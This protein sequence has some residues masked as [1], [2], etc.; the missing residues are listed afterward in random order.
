MTEV[1]LVQPPIQDFYLT[2]KRTI[3]YG[4]ACIAACLRESGI[5]VE[6]LDA[7]AVNKSRVLEVP[8]EMG[9]LKPYYGR[10]DVSAFSLFHQFRHYGYSHQHLGTLIRDK[11]PF[12]VGISSLFTAYSSQALTTAET[13]KRFYPDCWIVMGGHHPTQLPEQVMACK[14]VD[15]V[16]R[17]EGEV[18]ML[19][20]VKALLN[21]APLEHVPGIVFRKADNTLFMS[22][23]AWMDSKTIYPVPAMDLVNRKFYARKQ[24][25]STVVVAGRGCPM[26]CSYC[27]VGASSSW[28]RFRQRKVDEVIAEIESQIARQDIGFIDFEDENLTLNRSWFLDLL[29]QIIARFGHLDVELRAMNGLFPPSLDAGMVAAMKAAGFKTLNLA[30]GSTSAAQLARFHRPDVRALFEK[31]LDWAS[32][33]SMDTVSY[34][35]AAAPGQDPRDS[36]SDLLYLAEK[37]TLVGFSV[38]YPAP[39]SADYSLCAVKG[40]LPAHFSLMRSTALP[41][42]DTTTRVQAVTLLRLSRLLNFM[43]LLKDEG[44]EMPVPERCTQTQVDDFADRITTGKKLLQWFFHDGWIRGVEPDGTVYVH[45]TDEA[46]GSLFLKRI[47][48]IALAGSTAGRSPG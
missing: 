4:L 26:Q 30:L 47:R 44:I 13:I 48:K 35:I 17:G 10:P 22:E 40:L 11:K 5:H 15:F 25:G 33:N 2:A 28:A 37:Q 16:L 24:R 46:L 41:V 43:K 23:P 21:S 39:G 45:S 20:L 27:S 1:L 29:D 9:Y 36:V 12:V 6:I 7:L 32:E 18:G 38:F 8:D 34:L 19:A 3:P 31:C 42:A 14:A